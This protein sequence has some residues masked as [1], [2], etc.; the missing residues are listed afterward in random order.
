[1]QKQAYIYFMANQHN[2][3]LYL[4]VTNNLVRR[5]AEHK[6][7]INKGFFYKYNCDK[8][9]YFETFASISDAISREKQLKNWKRE[10]KNELIGR[11]NPGWK[12]LSEEI[13]ANEEWIKAVR[14]HYGIAGQA[15]NDEGQARNDRGQA[16][17]DE[18]Q[19]RND[20]GQARNDRGQASNDGKKRPANNESKEQ[21]KK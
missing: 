9:V 7:K 17:N 18:G 8:L 15:R 13:G 16:R 11:M 10:W 21:S 20:E 6:A 5:T 3:V 2:T 1:M 4:G 12:D 14:E 19:A